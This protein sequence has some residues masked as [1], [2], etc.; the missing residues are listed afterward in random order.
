MSQNPQGALPP[1]QCRTTLRPLI[2]VRKPPPTLKKTLITG[3]KREIPK[4]G[5]PG[6]ATRWDLPPRTDRYAIDVLS[7]NAHV[8]RETLFIAGS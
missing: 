2:Q 5:T 6:R 7:L 3:E 4:A 8:L 1:V